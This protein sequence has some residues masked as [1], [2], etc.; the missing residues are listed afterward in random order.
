[1]QDTTMQ[2]VLDDDHPLSTKGRSSRLSIS[3]AMSQGSYQPRSNFRTPSAALIQSAVRSVLDDATP[4]SIV[5]DDRSDGGSF[6]DDPV[7]PKNA[8]SPTLESL[9]IEPLPPLPDEQDRKRF[10]VSATLE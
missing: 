8:F 9:Q 1:M 10:I 4:G 7:T 6:L 3:T 5:S 2:R